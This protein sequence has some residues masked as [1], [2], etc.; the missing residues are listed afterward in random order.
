MRMIT[1]RSSLLGL[2]LRVKQPHVVD[3]ITAR[4]DKEIPFTLRAQV[5]N[6]YMRTTKSMVPK[7]KGNTN[8]PTWLI[9]RRRTDT[10]ELSKR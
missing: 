6:S 8:A 7:R 4:Y 5:I 1:V 10:S 3:E 9:R 2:L